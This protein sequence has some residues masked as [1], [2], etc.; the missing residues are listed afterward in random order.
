MT[1]SELAEKELR[2][3][4]S[5]AKNSGFEEFKELAGKIEEYHFVGILNSIRT[6]VS[7]AKSEQTNSVI[8]GLISRA[9]GF[10]NLENLFALI[11]LRCSNPV[12]PLVNR[13]QLSYEQKKAMQEQAGA[14]R[15]AREAE[16]RK[17]LE[18]GV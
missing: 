17:A 1:D 4:I 10:G 3:W 5:K 18:E 6:G 13:Y 2:K 8:Q 7:S 15:R 9:Y 14:R 12:V 11:L 16:K